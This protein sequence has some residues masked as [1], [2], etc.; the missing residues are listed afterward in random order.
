MIPKTIHYVWLSGE[1][2][3]NEIQECIDSWKKEMPDY[4][5]K[6]WNT[7]T[8][9]VDSIPWVK[10]AYSL[11]KWAFA[12]DYIRL[13]ALY[14]EGGIYLDSDVFVRKSFNSFLE[15]RFFSA[16]E[17]HPNSPTINEILSHIDKDGNRLDNTIL[18]GFQI[19]AAIIGS[20]PKHPYVKECLDFY[21]NRHYI[22]QDGSLYENEILPDIMA[23]KAEKYGFKYLNKY[24]ILKDDM[25][26][27]PSTIF[28]SS[29]PL[30]S[31]ES[32][33]IHCCNGSWRFMPKGFINIAIYN[34]KKFIK[35][36]LEIMKLR[37]KKT[38]IKQ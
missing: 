5:I 22:N 27:Y 12:A 34:I 38:F 30:S 8:F 37:D 9:D 18:H 13:Y 14:N 29:I 3:P 17:F 36:I 16:V 24:Q 10:E 28:A 7:K 31:K 20:C 2:L 33:A 6:E 21:K 15:H 25:H 1:K 11:K 32:I 23:R 19:Q 35:G 26:I 4:T